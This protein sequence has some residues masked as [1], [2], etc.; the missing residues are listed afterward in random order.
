MDNM[1]S[2]EG[3]LSHLE[4]QQNVAVTDSIISGSTEHCDAVN[5]N[6]AL[7]SAAG[8]E[9]RKKKNRRKKGKSK[10]M[11]SENR[12]VFMLSHTYI[13]C[14]HKCSNISGVPDAGCLHDYASDHHTLRPP[15]SKL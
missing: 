3:D 1:H 13:I 12:Y 6:D 15:S 7:I 2:V 9:K 14:R 11:N 4:S 8:N 5:G 10:A